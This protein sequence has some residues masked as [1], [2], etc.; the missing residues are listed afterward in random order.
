MGTVT[1]V[2]DNTPGAAVP[3][4]AACLADDS[5]GRTTSVPLS[6]EALGS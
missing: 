5:E 4:R 1:A 2:F 3:G 6:A